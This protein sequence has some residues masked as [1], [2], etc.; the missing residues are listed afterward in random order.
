MS[1]FVIL[2]LVFVIIL[3]LDLINAFQRKLAGDNGSLIQYV[4]FI[5]I[6]S[7]LIILILNLKTKADINLYLE[8]NLI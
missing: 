7:I 4:F 2:M 8:E 1:I 5:D 3:I 6:F